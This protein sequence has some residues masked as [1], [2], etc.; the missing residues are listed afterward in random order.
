MNKQRPIMIEF[1]LEIVTAFHK[2]YDEKYV[3]TLS[4]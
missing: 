4:T 1:I 2:G 3:S